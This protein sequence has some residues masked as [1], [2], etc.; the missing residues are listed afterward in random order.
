MMEVDDDKITEQ[1]TVYENK[2]K[3]VKD[4][5]R[6]EL[7][8][9][10]DL[11]N[12]ISEAKKNE[13]TQVMILERLDEYESIVSR[14][15]ELAERKED[16]ESMI[17]LA[18][19][20]QYDDM[21]QEHLKVWAKYEE[22]YEAI[23]LAME[24]RKA[25]SRLLRVTI[26]VKLAAYRINEAQRSMRLKK[27]IAKKREQL[28]IIEFARLYLEHNKREKNCHQLIGRIKA[29]KSK[30]QELRHK[31]ENAE[32]QNYRLARFNARSKTQ[33]MPKVDLSHFLINKK[34]SQDNADTASV[35]SMALEQEYLDSDDRSKKKSEPI[36]PNIESLRINI[37]EDYNIDMDIDTTEF[38]GLN[39]QYPQSNKPNES[40]KTNNS[41][42]Y[43]KQGRSVNRNDTAPSKMPSEVDRAS[44]PK[45]SNDRRNNERS[46][47]ESQKVMNSNKLKKKFVEEHKQSENVSPNARKTPYKRENQQAP[48]TTLKD[49][50]GKD[51]QQ[52][53]VPTPAKMQCFTR[54]NSANIQSHPV[55]DAQ[56]EKPRRSSQEQPRRSSQEQPRR[57]SQEQQF[58]SQQSLSS[59][60]EMQRHSSQ[61][62]QHSNSSQELM[63][64]QHQQQQQYQPD[65]Q[66]VFDPRDLSKLP[67]SNAPRI[68][69][70]QN[71]NF[72]VKTPKNHYSLAQQ[73]V[74]VNSQ[75]MQQQ[76]QQQHNQHQQQQK[77]QLQQRR[78]ETPM[79]SSMHES[80]RNNGSAM[81]SMQ[82][83][84]HNIDSTASNY[85][86]QM[87][88]NLNVTPVSG[89]NVDPA[90][91]MSTSMLSSEM[92]ISV[93][94][95]S[96]ILGSEITEPGGSAELARRLYE[97]S[98]MASE[99]G[100]FDYEKM[101]N[102]FCSPVA[103]SKNRS[104]EQNTTESLPI[105]TQIRPDPSNNEPK[106]NSQEPPGG[107]MFGAFAKKS[108][109]MNRF[110]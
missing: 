85:P 78:Q 87:P 92:N 53:P 67:Q 61:E 40:Q 3:E 110:F 39:K 43:K 45:E 75:H 55:Q 79:M 28:K 70:V 47:N 20:K 34:L 76:Q 106:S 33:Q 8:T 96:A 44:Q 58:Q 7:Q 74:P 10:R 57:S 107:F 31:V 2:I 66:N 99:D 63:M 46:N 62:M 83:S 14:E 17:T 109:T 97:D 93:D 27:Q 77:Q 29:M 30:A 98:D 12:K 72:V 51:Y 21:L 22:E 41:D 5:I 105:N 15:L 19:I 86:M 38:E 95:I 71:V 37:D 50:T 91:M 24:R 11:K 89:M 108:T 32:K 23:P 49:T 52:R 16:S 26:Q 100:D 9:R 73:E 48:P 1:I 25:E 90:G 80:S 54:D 68:K 88:Q 59:S 104:Q 4:K 56:L 18:M 101:L 69:S 103:A 6:D 13:A 42:K 35:Y 36:P 84:S 102:K 65:D 82:E 64:Q 60:Q 94:N 81:P